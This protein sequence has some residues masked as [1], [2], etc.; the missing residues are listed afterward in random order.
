MDWGRF[1]VKRN[2]ISY[3]IKTKDDTTDKTKNVQKCIHINKLAA[4]V[5][6][7]EHQ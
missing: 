1:E 5:N 6:D 3:V 2:L 7:S 4:S